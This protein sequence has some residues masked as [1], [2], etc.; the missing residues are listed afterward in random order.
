MKVYALAFI[1]ITFGYALG[2]LSDELSYSKGF[3]HAFKA[4]PTECRQEML[5]NYAR[6]IFNQ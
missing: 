1:M 4:A 2:Q 6:F 5:K 3:I